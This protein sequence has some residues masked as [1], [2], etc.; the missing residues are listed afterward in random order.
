MQELLETQDST[1]V[2]LLM[3]DIYMESAIYNVTGIP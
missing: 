2:A 3:C 1:V